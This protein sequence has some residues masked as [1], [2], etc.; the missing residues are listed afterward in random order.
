MWLRHLLRLPMLMGIVSVI[1]QASFYK[2]GIVLRLWLMSVVRLMRIPFARE[3]ILQL[4]MFPIQMYVIG[5]QQQ[6]QP[7][8]TMSQTC[9]LTL[10]ISPIIEPRMDCELQS[11]QRAVRGRGIM[12]FRLSH[13]AETEVTV[14]SGIFHRTSIISPLLRPILRL[15]GI[16]L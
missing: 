14:M 7:D 3:I 9:F 4:S 6:I 1:N 15:L 8:E 13:E 5:D 16:Q 12:L 10:P 11:R 2:G